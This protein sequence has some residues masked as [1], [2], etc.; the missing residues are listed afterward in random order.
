MFNSSSGSGE[1]TQLRRP[2]AFLGMQKSM[3]TEADLE[4]VQAGRQTDG[5]V[6]ALPCV[7]G[8]DQT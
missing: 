2:D 8:R 1:P 4:G 3:Q 7:V 5:Q 6:N